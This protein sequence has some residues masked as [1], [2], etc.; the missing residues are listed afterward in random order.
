M[1]REAT[2]PNAARMGNASH[3]K[4]KAGAIVPAAQS[5]TL[6]ERKTGAPGPAEAADTKPAAIAASRK[7]T[8]G[9]LA[10]SNQPVRCGA[11]QWAQSAP[12]VA[13]NT[14]NAAYPTINHESARGHSSCHWT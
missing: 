3:K 9:I 5:Y 8:R 12:K 2:S 14:G 13:A 10:T 11:Y 6:A 7:V 4:P 1:K